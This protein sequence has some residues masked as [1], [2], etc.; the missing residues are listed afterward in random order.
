MKIKIGDNVLVTTGKDK[1]KKGKVQ[2]VYKKLEKVVVE[3]VNIRTKHVK[4]TSN[5]AGERVQFEAPL[6][7]SNVMLVCPHC[8]KAVRVGYEIPDEG[9]KYRV[10]K[11]CNATLDVAVAA[12][13]KK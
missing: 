9:K 2:K 1:G 12:K 11:K 8:S 3:K 10:C 13:S 6:S 4:K 5:R 7:I